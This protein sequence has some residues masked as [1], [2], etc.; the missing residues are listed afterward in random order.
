MLRHLERYVHQLELL[1]AVRT[2]CGEGRVVE[3]RSRTFRA[4]GPG[5]STPA[6]RARTSDPSKREHRA[7]PKPG[8]EEH[9]IETVTSALS[10]QHGPSQDVLGHV[11]TPPGRRDELA[12]DRDDQATAGV[13]SDGSGPGRS[14]IQTHRRGPSH[15]RPAARRGQCHR[16]KMTR[17]GPGPVDDAIGQRHIESLRW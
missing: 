5:R 6:A 14:Q 15:H 4:S 8:L 2:G 10:G 7:D 11:P 17:S 13:T 1:H 12:E 9:D 3:E 16:E